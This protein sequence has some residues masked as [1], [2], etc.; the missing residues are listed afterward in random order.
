M[1]QILFGKVGRAEFCLSHCSSAA[2]EKVKNLWTN[3]DA[4]LNGPVRN[5]KK[6][7]N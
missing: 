3:V 6:I 1:G 7:I 5:V 4:H 2:A